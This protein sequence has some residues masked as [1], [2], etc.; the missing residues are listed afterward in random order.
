MAGPAAGAEELAE[1]RRPFWLVELEEAGRTK[2]ARGSGGNSMPQAEQVFG[3]VAIMTSLNTEAKPEKS[4]TGNLQ[5][6]RLPATEVRSSRRTT[7]SGFILA[8]D[9]RDAVWKLP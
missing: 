7:E 2:T 6:G 3:I 1:V 5:W 4:V 8:A 9:T